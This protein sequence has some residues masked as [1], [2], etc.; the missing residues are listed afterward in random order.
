MMIESPAGHSLRRHSMQKNLTHLS[1]Q[2]ALREAKMKD[3]NQ[4]PEH[5]KKAAAILD[6]MRE[7]AFA[8]AREK[9]KKR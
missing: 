3:P 8:E 2:R 9:A 5:I 7:K 6:E 1:V 4:I